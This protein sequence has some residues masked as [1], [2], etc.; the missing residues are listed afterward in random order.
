MTDWPETYIGDGVYASFDGWHII[1]DL[2]AQP[3]DRGHHC[4]IALEPAVMIRLEQYEKDLKALA[5]ER[6]E[7]AG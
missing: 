5:I 2:R 3:D 6:R 4:R 7:K 1:L